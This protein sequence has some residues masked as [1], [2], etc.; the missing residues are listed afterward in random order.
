MALARR[1]TLAPLRMSNN[2]RCGYWSAVSPCTSSTQAGGPPRQQKQRSSATLPREKNT[3]DTL[4]KPV[5]CVAAVGRSAGGRVAAVAGLDRCDGRACRLPAGCPLWP[6][7]WAPPALLPAVAAVGPSAVA[8]AARSTGAA[9]LGGPLPV[10][11]SSGGPPPPWP[12][13]WAPPALPLLHAAGAGPAAAVAVWAGRSRT[14]CGC[15]A[16]TVLLLLAREAPLEQAAAGL[17]WCGRCRASGCGAPLLRLPD[18]RCCRCGFARG[19]PGGPAVSAAGQSN[20]FGPRAW[21]PPG[22]R[23][24]PG[25]VRA[26]AAE[27]AAN[28][29][30]GTPTPPQMEREGEAAANAAAAR[31]AV[32]RDRPA[33]RGG[34]ARRC[35]SCWHTESGNGGNESPQPAPVVLLVGRS[36]ETRCR[37]C[38]GRVRTVRPC[39][40]VA[41][42]RTRGR[43]RTTS[44]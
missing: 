10:V 9:G 28:C 11:S 37:R 17:R 2:L 13:P 43:E 15:R 32:W 3:Q 42:P 22:V 16:A 39:A 27:A 4:R 44:G 24:V 36:P 38:R 23:G 31:A 6:G 26:P 12:V 33:R 29:G 8:G 5:A 1:L 34:V 18:R 21:S 20:P 14:A 41:P 35:R 25:R 7:P 19:L 40:G 30:T